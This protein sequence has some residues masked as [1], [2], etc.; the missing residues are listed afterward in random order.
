[1]SYRQL[2]EQ[3]RIT[4]W[5]LRREGKSQADIARKLGCHRSTI[6]RELRRN[7]TLSGYDARCAHQ[8][9]EERRRHHRAA[10]TPD[11]GNLLGMLSTLGW[12]KEKQKE[13]ILRHH[14][15]LKLSVEQM[16]SR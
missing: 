16:M 4:I 10:A 1:M 7:N 9:A 11:L 3:D 15:E 6:S 8:Q 13:F 14:P 2:T 5:S 12:S